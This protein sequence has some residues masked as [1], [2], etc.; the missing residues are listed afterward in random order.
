MKELTI[1]NFDTEIQNADGITIVDFWADWCGPCRMIAPILEE[2]DR[3][4]E[5]VTVMKVNVDKEPALADRFGINAIP[6][7]I[8]FKNGEIVKQ[9]TGLYPRDALDLIIKEIRR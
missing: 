3:E 4:I 1:Q 7:L 6:T 9:K 8:F 2:V 5:D